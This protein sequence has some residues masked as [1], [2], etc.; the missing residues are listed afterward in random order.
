[1]VER[2][3]KYAAV[4]IVTFILGVSL[5][6][7]VPSPSSLL[8]EIEEFPPEPPIAVD[9]ARQCRSDALYIIDKLGYYADD[10][11]VDERCF[12]LQ[13]SLVEAVHQGDL[14][15]IRAAIEHG[16]NPGSPGWWRDSGDFERPLPMAGNAAAV[17]LL[18][19]NGGDVNDF[20][21]CCMT[22]KSLLMIALGKNDVETT[23]L[24]LSRGADVNFKSDFEGWSLFD[25]VREPGHDEANAFFLRVC[26]QNLRCRFESRSKKILS[27]LPLDRLL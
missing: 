21:Y 18:L 1:M 23:K 8:F 6:L 26:D 2:T 7:V 19:D 22:H 25:T 14:S 16:A 11:I 12:E 27:I 13:R 9:R 5:Y 4:A 10:E 20:Y 3:L 17:K 24:L 15:S